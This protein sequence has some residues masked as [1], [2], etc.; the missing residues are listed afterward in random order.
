MKKIYFLLVIALLASCNTLKRAEKSLNS[1]DYNRAFDILVEKYQKGLSDRKYN[2]YLPAL[3][4][5][6]QRMVSTEETRIENMG[7]ENNP[8]YYDDIY[9][10]LLNLEKRQNKLKALLPL[11]Q[12]GK[13]LEFTT[14]NYSE[15]IRNAKEDYTGYLYDSGLEKLAGNDKKEIRNAYAEFQKVNELIP[16]YGNV[17]R[18][19][20]SARLKGTEFVLIEINNNSRQMIPRRLEND[21]LEMNTYGLNEFWTKFHNRKQN[22][23]QYDYLVRMDLNRIEVSPE[24]FHTLRERY[25]KEIQDGWE[26]VYENGQQVLDSLGNPVKQ[27]RYI[28]VRAEVDETIQEKD[29]L[30]EGRVNLIHIPSQQTVDHERLYSQ[31]GFR[32]HFAQFQGDR[33]ALDQPVLALLQNRAVPF[34]SHEQ[35]VYDCGEELKDQLKTLLKRRF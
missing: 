23:I 9:Y 20:E 27:D 18:L 31:F 33:R 16:G 35:M 24:R 21:L 7:K 14:K 8:S 17:S 15:A 22:N 11:Y 4:K 13:Q 26:Y 28:N 5:A 30:V 19:I 6:Y 29:A 1:G 10:A 3:Q 2:E 12:N 25:E 32:N 34:P